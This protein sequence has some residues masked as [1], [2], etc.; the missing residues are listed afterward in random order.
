MIDPS[1]L[2]A[3]LV[4]DSDT[5]IV[6]GISAGMGALGGVAHALVPDPAKP[7]WWRRVVLGAIA[8]VA[9]LWVSRP[10]DAVALIAS[11]LV[12]GYAGEAIMS[13][14]EAK[15]KLLAANAQ[16]AD[17]KQQK[18]QAVA[19]VQRAITALETTTAP[20]PAAAQRRGGQT[21]GEDLAP[22]PGAPAAE[23]R[24]AEVLRE[25]R[26]RYRGA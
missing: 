10:D 12:A 17:E 2:V 24:A 15:S 6:C 21:F 3:K 20:A 9:I 22:A 25:L 16:I 19:D 23:S 4:H 1:A 18:Q 14:L 5:W 11:S 7:S 13:A 26:A 8:A